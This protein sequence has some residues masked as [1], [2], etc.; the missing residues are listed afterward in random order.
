MVPKGR[1]MRQHCFW[2]HPWPATMGQFH[3]TSW[4]KK[5][6]PPHSVNIGCVLQ[7]LSHFY[8]SNGI[9]YIYIYA[10]IYIEIYIGPVIRPLKIWKC[11]TWKIGNAQQSYTSSQKSLAAGEGDGERGRESWKKNRLPMP[12]AATCQEPPELCTRLGRRVE[13]E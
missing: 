11:R 1:W 12:K 6:I 2:S 10:Y 13:L 8:H 4:L 9:T 3:W 5:R 7:S